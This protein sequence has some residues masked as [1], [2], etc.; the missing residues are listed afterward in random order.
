MHATS[1]KQ[2]AIDAIQSLPISVPPDEIEAW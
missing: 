2:E 1:V